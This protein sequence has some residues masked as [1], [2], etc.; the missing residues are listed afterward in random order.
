MRK[1]VLV[2]GMKCKGCANTV[3]EKF[4]AIEGVESVEINLESKKVIVESKTK[5]DA[6]TF[7]SALS[8]TKYSVV[9]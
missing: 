4:E 9:D 8:G 1:E 2:E 3:Q 6:E 5:I 7:R